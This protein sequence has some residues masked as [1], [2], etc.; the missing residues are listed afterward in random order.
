[1]ILTKR[2]MISFAWKRS[3]QT[4]GKLQPI[5]NLSYFSKEANIKTPITSESNEI[6][7]GKKYLPFLHGNHLFPVGSV[8]LIPPQTDYGIIPEF[9]SKSRVFLGTLS[10]QESLGPLC[11]SQQ[12]LLC[13]LAPWHDQ[14][15]P[16]ALARLVSPLDATS[17]Q[18]AMEQRFLWAHWAMAA[19]CLQRW[20]EE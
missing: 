18:N 2:E 3:Y 17:V 13:Y 16:P 6:C 7:G 4:R 12:L 20:G 8:N 1:M 9:T 5:L 10:H 14:T 11:S 15:S 19:A